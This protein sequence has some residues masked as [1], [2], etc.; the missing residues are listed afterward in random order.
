MSLFDKFKKRGAA[1]AASSDRV[2]PG[3]T[4]TNGFPVLTYGPTMQ[5]AAEEWTCRIF[6][7]VE[8]EHTFTW[9]DLHAMPQTTLHTDIHCVTGWSKLDTDWVGVRFTDFLEAVR[10][11]CGAI[12]PEAK[13]VMQHASGGYTTNVPMEE[14]LAADVLVAHTFGGAPITAEHG[15]PVRFVV[16]KL[17]FWKSAKWLNG[18]EFM[19]EDRRGFWERCGYHNHGDPWREERFG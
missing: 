3:Q 18:I 16:P 19:T 2:P 1:T 13:F 14:M 6:G 9:A 15:G 7:A 4:L 17:Y 8:R 11:Q 12:S 5:I 10:A